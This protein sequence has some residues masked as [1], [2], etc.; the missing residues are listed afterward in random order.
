MKSDI[1]GLFNF[2]RNIFI[3]WAHKINTIITGQPTT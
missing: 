1:Y 2:I 3:L